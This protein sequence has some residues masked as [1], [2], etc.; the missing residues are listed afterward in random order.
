[1]EVIL[2]QDGKVIQR[3]RNLAGIRRYVGKHIIDKLSINTIG[4]SSY[5]EGKLS[6][7]FANKSS[8]ETNFASFEV[9][10]EM[11]RNWRNVYG[12][13]LLVNGQDQGKVQ[14]SN[15]ALEPY[16]GVPNG[17]SASHS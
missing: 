7:L 2:D 13:P 15:P 4:D 11:V 8:F 17:S 10:K 16:Y 1:M 6:I 12:A 9:L 14:H 3:S 5:P